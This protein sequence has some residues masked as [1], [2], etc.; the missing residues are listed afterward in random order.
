MY[1]DTE[2]TSNDYKILGKLK[3]ARNARIKREIEIRNQQFN[4]DI[5][6]ETLIMDTMKNAKH[7]CPVATI[8]CFNAFGCTDPYLIRDILALLPPDNARECAIK[9]IQENEYKMSNLP[10]S[11][12][13]MIHAPN[14]HK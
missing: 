7:L 5:K 2:L 8:M 9:M 4:A 10:L 3:I 6:Q 11:E 12:A 13:I 1:N 14:P